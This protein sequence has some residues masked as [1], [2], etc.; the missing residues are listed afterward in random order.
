M[1]PRFIQI[2][3]KAVRFDAISYID[4]LESGRAMVIL[5][6]LPPEKAHISVDIQ[7]ARMLREYFETGEVTAN[8]ARD[9]R[10]TVEWPRALPIRA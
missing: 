1:Q 7:E 10:T 9:S 5:S 4:F 6:G 3:N 2:N 8:P